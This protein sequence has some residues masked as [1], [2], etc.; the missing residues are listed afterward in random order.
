[1]LT[2]QKL[3]GCCPYIVSKVIIIQ[4]K[5]TRVR[6]NYRV[7]SRVATQ[8]NALLCAYIVNGWTI[9]R[10]DF[11]KPYVE[12]TRRNCQTV[13]KFQK[14]QQC[15]PCCFHCLID[16]VT[17]T[18]LLQWWVG[19]RAFA[20]TPT[21]PYAGG[22]GFNPRPHHTKDVIKLVLETLLL[23]AQHYKNMYDF[24]HLKHRSQLRWI[25]SMESK[26]YK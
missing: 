23:R 24:S 5:R 3:F 16:F 18:W 1:M 22:P 21:S 20:P 25:S 4:V 10:Y 7:W 11:F 2:Q 13:T 14:A 6:L 19:C 26:L 9:L 17:M 12:F 15:P 8:T